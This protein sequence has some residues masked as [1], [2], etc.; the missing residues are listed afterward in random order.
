MGLAYQQTRK[1]CRYFIVIVIVVVVVVVVVL[2]VVVVGDLR[3]I[4]G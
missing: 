2:I 1:V 3:A 4:L